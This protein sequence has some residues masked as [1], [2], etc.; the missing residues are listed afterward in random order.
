MAIFEFRPTALALRLQGQD[1][2]ALRLYR[3]AVY[4]KA[5][6][7]MLVVSSS[8]LRFELATLVA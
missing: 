3:I 6:T 5:A 4:A 2:F 7:D 1:H 8:L